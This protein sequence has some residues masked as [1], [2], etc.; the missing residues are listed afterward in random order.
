MHIRTST[1]LQLQLLGKDGSPLAAKVTQQQFSRRRAL[2][3]A[4]TCL[5]ISAKR[6]YAYSKDRRRPELLLADYPELPA[7]DGAKKRT[8]CAPSRWHEG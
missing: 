8:P 4:M 5:M 2:M 7:T 1:Y 6:S 3:A